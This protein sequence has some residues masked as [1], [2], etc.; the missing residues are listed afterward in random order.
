VGVVD[1]VVLDLADQLLWLEPG[2]GCRCRV[3]EGRPPFSI[4]AVDPFPR[5][6]EYE[7]VAPAEPLDFLL[8]PFALG[9]IAGVGH[10]APHGRVVEQVG[11]R[12]LDVPPTTLL[13]PEA[14]LYRRSN[15][16]GVFQGFDERASHPLDVFRVHVLERVRPD[17]FLGLVAEHPLDGGAVVADGAVRPEDG[18]DIRGV[19]D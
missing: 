4:Q 3:D 1:D 14:E 12:G 9:H 6:V 18:D 19:L 8:R 11:A 10:H 17:A 15:D 13:V 7:A 5:R 16:A 2:Q